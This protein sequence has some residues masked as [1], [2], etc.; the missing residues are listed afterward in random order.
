[1][2]WPAA[3]CRGYGL[4]L[5]PLPGPTHPYL[6]ASPPCWALFVHRVT[7]DA[8]AAQHPGAPG[9]R[10]ARSVAIHVAGLCLTLE[11]EVPPARGGRLLARLVRQLPGLGWLDPPAHRGE[12]TI[13][14]V[15]AAK[16][17]ADHV[18][19]VLEWARDVW[20]AWRPHHEAT[21]ARAEPALED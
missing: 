17:G 15:H 6:G 11:H 18:E 8:Y 20:Q 7:V 2:H 16:P 1:V 14:D 10:S 5:P 13:G 19:R 12:M 4:S 9:R 3:P 21:R